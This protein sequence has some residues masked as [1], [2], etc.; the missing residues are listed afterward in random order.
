MKW[1][2]GWWRRG[3]MPGVM[4]TVGIRGGRDPREGTRCDRELR[5]GETGK[6]N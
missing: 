4:M 5:I 2:G 3:A 1:R 6:G